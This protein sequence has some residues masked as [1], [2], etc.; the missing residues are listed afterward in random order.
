MNEFVFRFNRP[1]PR[2][3][4]MVFLRVLELAVVHGPVR[5]QDLIVNNKLKKTPPPPPAGRGKPPSLDR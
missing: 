3:R 4:G 5:Y 1:R 2:S